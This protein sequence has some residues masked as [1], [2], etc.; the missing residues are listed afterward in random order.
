MRHP[1]GA[2][3]GNGRLPAKYRVPIVLCHL[4]EMTHAEAACN[5][6]GPSGM[7]RG[8]VSRA[9]ELLRARLAQRLMLS[10]GVL[11]T[12]L[13]EQAALAAV[14]RAW[15][16]T[17]VGVAT[18]VAAGQVA[19]GAVSAAAVTFSERTSRSMFMT[20]LIWPRPP[21]WPAGG[22]VGIAM[23][24]AARQ[25]DD[26]KRTRSSAPL[27][28]SHGRRSPR[29]RPRTAPSRCRS[30]DAFLIGPA[31]QCTGQRCTFGTVIG[32]SA[33]REP[34]RASRPRQAPDGRFRFDLDP[35]KSDALAGE[36]PPWHD[37]LIAAIAAGHGPTWISAG[38]AAERGRT[39]IGRGGPADPRPHPRYPG[40]RRPKCSCPR[41]VAGDTRDGVDL[42]ALLASGK[43]DFH[44][45]RV[46][47]IESNWQHGLDRPGGEVMTDD[48]GRFEIKGMGR[49]QVTVLGIEGPGIEHAHIAVLDRTPRTGTPAGPGHGHRL[50]TRA[51]RDTDLTLYGAQF[52]HV[53][54]PSKPITA[55]SA[56]RGPAGPCR[57]SDHGPDPGK[58]LGGDD[59]DRQ[60]RTIPGWRVYRRPKPTAWRC[61]PLRALPISKPGRSSPIRLACGR[62][63][64]PSI[65][66]GPWVSLAGSSTGRPG[67]AGLCDFVVCKPLREQ[68]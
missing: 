56:S 62:S 66:P 37:A 48:S 68:P 44:G 17:M 34:G 1:P 2:P 46:P 11:I 29:R 32:A 27:R 15:I 28:W 58:G 26:G 65:W 12:V 30:A 52:E 16:D 67:P 19:V 10:G 50:P 43:L 18:K 20:R 3:R 42:E 38:I 22:A 7:V 35:V 57:M 61:R 45:I 53:V 60:G 25:N 13:S 9:R 21:C 14:P 4:E 54:G 8:R 31:I 47:T 23:A 64:S 5:Q 41:E 6:G 63:T 39:A 59:Q 51:I 36:G 49:D 55:S 24:L 33:L 40:P